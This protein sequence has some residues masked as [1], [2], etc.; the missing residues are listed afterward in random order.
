MKTQRF[1]VEASNFADFCQLF[2]NSYIHQAQGLVS[3]FHRD[4]NKELMRAVQESAHVWHICADDR[5][6]RLANNIFSAQ[7]RREAPESQAAYNTTASPSHILGEYRER[8][9][10]PNGWRSATGVEV[11]M[12][13]FKQCRG[14]YRREMMSADLHPMINKLLHDPALNIYIKDWREMVLEYPHESD[15][16]AHKVAYTQDGDKGERDIQTVTS[17]GK[18]LKR[19][20]PAM[21]DHLLRD[22]VALAATVHSVCKFVQTT[23]EMI[24]AVQ[25]N[26]ATSCMKSCHFEGNDHPYRVYAPEYGWHMAVRYEGDDMVGRAVCLNFGDEK[27]FVRTYRYDAREDRT[28][29]DE[30]LQAWL[31]EQGYTHESSW[32]DYAKLKRIEGNNG[33]FVM[34]YLDGNNKSFS[35]C[36]THLEI[37]DCGDYT[38]GNTSGWSSG[39]YDRTCE[40]CGDGMDDDDSY[41]VG[42]HEDRIVCRNCLEGDYVYAY[43]RRG[44]Q[45]YIPENDALYVDGERYHDEYLSDNSIVELHNSDYVH[46]DN[47]LFLT[48]GDWVHIDDFHGG[49]VVELGDGSGDYAWSK[50]CWQCKHTDQWHE[51]TSERVELDDGS[52]VHEDYA[53]EYQTEEETEESES[54]NV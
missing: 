8:K 27:V 18:Y 53:D 39:G 3:V 37:N 35:C 22:F 30:V 47:A 43:G 49:E 50:D 25:R 9:Y 51:D 19:H 54:E 52:Y 32:P 34:P 31:K 42:M 28:T 41:Y 24:E 21:P 46:I 10:T 11:A 5:I 29:T 36:G 33:A 16:D 44:N 6:L 2:I 1:H 4:T 15:L 17:L 38:G 20:A 45:Y 23:E 12:H 40:D 7:R 26:K 48:N 14:W 13:L